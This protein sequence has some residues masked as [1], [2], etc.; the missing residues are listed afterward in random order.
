M[1]HILKILPE[2][3]KPVKLGLKPFEIRVNDCDFKLHDELELRE[4]SRYPDEYQFTGRPT[5]GIPH[6]RGMPHRASGSRVCRFWLL[7]HSEA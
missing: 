1:R 5:C 3:Y 2:F 4:W 7:L 6:R